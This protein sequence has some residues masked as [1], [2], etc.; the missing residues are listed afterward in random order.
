MKEP[1]V[2]VAF[3]VAILAAELMCGCASQPSKPASREASTEGA[4]DNHRQQRVLK[5][6]IS[7]RLWAQDVQPFR[8]E[9]QP[10]TESRAATA[11]R[12]SGA[13]DS[14]RRHGA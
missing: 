9:S 7:A 6:Y 1:V 8:V 2:V 4:G 12:K 10:T 5:C 3:A 13:L 14:P 11:R